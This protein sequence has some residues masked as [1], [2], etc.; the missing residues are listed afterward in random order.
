MRLDHDVVCFGKIPEHGDFVRYNADGA[1]A[2]EFDTWFR[3]GLHASRSRL[4]HSL[5]SVAQTAGPQRFVFCP[6]TTPVLLFGVMQMSEDATGRTY[7]FVVATEVPRTEWSGLSMAHLPVSSVSF[8]DSAEALVTDA[9]AGNVTRSSLKKRLLEVDPRKVGSDA[10]GEHEAVRFLDLMTFKGLA[11]GIW[12]SFDDSRKYLLFKNLSDALA[13]LRG[14]IPARF[15]L[16]LRFPIAPFSVLND[17]EGALLLRDT[18]AEVIVGFWFRV[19][20]AIADLQNVAPSFFWQA[21]A[22]PAPPEETEAAD[23]SDLGDHAPAGVHGSNAHSSNTHDSNTHDSSTHDRVQHVLTETA[24]E[25]RIGSYQRPNGTENEAADAPSSTNGASDATSGEERR[26]ELLYF[27]RP[28]PP[29]GFTQLLPVK[30]VET[31]ICRL[32]ASSGEKA[33]MVA[34]S[35]PRTMGE[36]LESETASLLDVIDAVRS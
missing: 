32:E 7:P 36:A 5:K 26:P 30:Q 12:G 22:S 24:S 23:E 13:P 27:F 20:H 10:V 33:A 11:E 6:T 14:Q 34:L 1:A 31:N 35:I 15:S 25:F 2:R 28:P 17:D 8:L 9:V 4:G 21:W 3:E 18:P 16:G 29:N 19:V